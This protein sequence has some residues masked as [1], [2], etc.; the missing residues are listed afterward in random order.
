MSVF[1]MPSPRSQ[2]V[3]LTSP[4]ALAAVVIVI[5]G[6]FHFFSQVNL[7]RDRAIKSAG[8]LTESLA[9]VIDDQVHR[10][11]QSLAIVTDNIAASISSP[12]DIPDLRT[13]IRQLPSFPELRGLL[14][15][16]PDFSIVGASQDPL[17]LG[18]Y[19]GSPE[20]AAIASHLSQQESGALASMTRVGLSVGAVIDGRA[21]GDGPESMSPPFI[22]VSRPV[23]SANG[24]LMGY[25]IAILNVPYL[26]FQHRS[27]TAP[28]GARVY[29]STYEGS[30]LATTSPNFS[31]GD[32]WTANNPI[33][34]QFLPQTERGKF[35]GDVDGDNVQ[36]IVS[37]RIT[38]D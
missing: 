21:V 20:Y 29:V 35:S 33:Y 24:S 23:R 38:R 4:L 27:L 17:A 8:N 5:T 13:R 2:F 31:A 3:R 9:R 16:R 26:E 11:I 25:L 28:H 1:P 36:D 19:L 30:L 15:V 37:F 22:P 34:K 18:D 10:S 32:N 12:Q 7:M 6:A 14:Y